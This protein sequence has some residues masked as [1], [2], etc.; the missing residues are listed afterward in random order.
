MWEGLIVPSETRWLA[1]ATLLSEEPLHADA[2]LP[3]R[4]ISSSYRIISEEVH[5]LGQLAA[6]T[7]DRSDRVS[8]YASF[9]GT[10]AACHDA[11]H[12]TH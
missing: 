4:T 1:G 7:Q 10:C 6:R 5:K 8:V 11:I 2:F 3:D 9:I 12:A